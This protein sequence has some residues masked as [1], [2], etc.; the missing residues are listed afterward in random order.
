MHDSCQFRRLKQEKRVLMIILVGSTMQKAFMIIQRRLN[1]KQLIQDGFTIWCLWEPI[2]KTW[3]TKN[4]HFLNPNQAFQKF[5]QLCCEH[6]KF[7]ERHQG[8]K[9]KGFHWLLFVYFLRILIN[10]KMKKFRLLGFTSFHCF[11][12][13]PFPF[14][15]YFESWTQQSEFNSDTNLQYLSPFN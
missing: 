15:H 3:V 13:L 12:S 4:I 5:Y 1:S 10:D 14:G 7:L 8:T 6:V 2:R 9:K 11:I